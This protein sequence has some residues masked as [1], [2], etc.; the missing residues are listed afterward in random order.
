MLQVNRKLTILCLGDSELSRE[1]LSC[2]IEKMQGWFKK[3]DWVIHLGDGAKEFFEIFNRSN[4]KQIHY[5][6]GNHDKNIFFAQKEKKE[7]IQGVNFLFYHGISQNPFLENFDTLINKIRVKFGAKANLGW[8]Y[9]NQ[10]KA[11][12]GKYDVVVS[13]HTHLPRMEKIGKTIFFC[14]G[15]LTTKS[16]NMGIPMSFGVIKSEKHHNSTLLQFRIYGFI[17]G[18]IKLIHKRDYVL[19]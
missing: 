11:L 16:L 13:G 9:Q 7:I 6:K 4:E 17:K 8:Y 14:P 10:A 2:L 15:G 3:A 18:A 5:L 1:E 12:G 19:S